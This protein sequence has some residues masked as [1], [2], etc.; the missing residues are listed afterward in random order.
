M[1]GG[2]QGSP[3]S[4]PRLLLGRTQI[5]GQILPWSFTSQWILS[6]REHCLVTLLLFNIMS[7]KKKCL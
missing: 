7:L 3:K 4:V 2:G 1:P 6:L 5:V